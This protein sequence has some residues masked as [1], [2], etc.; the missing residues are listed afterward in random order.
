MRVRVSLSALYRNGVDASTPVNRTYKYE[1]LF[2]LFYSKQISYRKQKNEKESCKWKPPLAVQKSTEKPIV[3][4]NELGLYFFFL[5]IRFYAFFIE[6]LE[7][8]IKNFIFYVFID[9]KIKFFW[10]KKPKR[11]IVPYRCF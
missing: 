7:F 4:A 2:C 8:Y 11:V 6:A 3:V 10:K 9:M 5:Y 1:R